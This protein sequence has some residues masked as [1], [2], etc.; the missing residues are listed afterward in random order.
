M[1]YFSRK[2]TRG[3]FKTLNFLR[4]VFLCS[5]FNLV[6]N[7]GCQW[8]GHAVSLQSLPIDLY[9]GLQVVSRFL[10]FSIAIT[11]QFGNRTLKSW[12]IMQKCPASKLF[13]ELK[14]YPTLYCLHNIL[15]TTISI[16][17]ILFAFYLSTADSD[18]SIK[19]ILKKKATVQVQESII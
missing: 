14:N 12:M 10:P 3:V 19:K 15:Q 7:C 11:Q 18:A 13:L 8:P 17:Q 2:T 9:T 5:I 16:E 6:G 4:I 1:D